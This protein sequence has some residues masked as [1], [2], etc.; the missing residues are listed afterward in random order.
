MRSPLLAFATLVLISSLVAAPPAVPH[1]EKLDA[2]PARMQ[3]F[4]DDGDLSGVVCVVGR[5]DGVV[6]ESATGL[7]DIAAKDAMKKDTLFRIASMTK[8]ITAI[9]IMILADEGK[10]SPD[11]DVA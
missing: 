11:D 1:P 6:H 7:R 3:K 8:P 4:I 5:K 2:I 10:L 9:G